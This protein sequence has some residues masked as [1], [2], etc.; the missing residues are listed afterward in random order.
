MIH[1]LLFYLKCKNL[2]LLLLSIFLRSLKAKRLC[3]TAT[4]EPDMACLG[5][6]CSWKWLNRYACHT[7]RILN[8][9][10]KLNSSFDYFLL[11]CHTES[12][13]MK[14]NRW[15]FDM[16]KIKCKRLQGS[17]WSSPCYITEQLNPVRFT[18]LS[19]A[20]HGGRSL[21][22]PL[23]YSEYLEVI[24]WSIPGFSAPT[25]MGSPLDTVK[26]W[27]LWKLSLPGWGTAEA[28]ATQTAPPSSRSCRYLC[29]TFNLLT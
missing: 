8:H 15:L 20:T 25:S 21:P 3:W 2:L 17:D 5:N 26:C 29:L 19:K 4:Y 28:Q 27:G 11:F 16:W 18:C 22:C 7:Y 10:Y 24:L 13:E 1:E 23:G 14:R 12:N 9:I 6:S